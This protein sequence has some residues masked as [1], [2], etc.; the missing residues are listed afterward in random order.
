MK[1]AHQKSSFDGGYDNKYWISCSLF[2]FQN[3][4]K[5]VTN[6]IADKKS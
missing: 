6:F 2:A 4:M 3:V 5:C 1:I